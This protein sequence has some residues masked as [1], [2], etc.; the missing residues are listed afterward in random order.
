MKPASCAHTASTVLGNPEPR[1]NERDRA[2]FLEICGVRRL[3]KCVKSEPFTENLRP[4][5]SMQA[6]VRT[7][8]PYIQKFMYHHNELSGVY[9]ELVQ[10][11][12]R[13]K[14]KRL[15]FGQVRSSHFV[16]VHTLI[17]D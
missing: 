10:N 3:S 12:I 17:T 6:M 11:G 14:I 15:Y 5:P 4:C 16:G 9:S 2:L 8:V 13:E 1:F 7:V